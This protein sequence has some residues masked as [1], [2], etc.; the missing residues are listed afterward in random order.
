LLVF[1][2]S[3]CPHCLTV[4]PEIKKL[5]E[6]DDVADFEVVAISVDTSANDWKAEI[7][8]GGFNWINCSDLN[9][10]NSKAADDYNIYATPSMVLL[11]KE[12][13]IIEKPITKNEL[14]KAI[15]ALTK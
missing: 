1:W 9:G 6:N 3:W 12:K 15:K 11:D 10:W 5:Y 2:A 4:L 14:K 8:K 7:K 13:N